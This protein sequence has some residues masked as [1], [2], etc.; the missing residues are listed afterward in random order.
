MGISPHVCV[1]QRPPEFGKGTSTNIRDAYTFIC[2]N[3]LG[4]GDEIILIGF[5]RRAFTV[6]CI[7]AF[8]HDVGLLT[9]TGLNTSTACIG[10]GRRRSAIVDFS[11]PQNT[12]FSVLQH[13]HQG[14]DIALLR[15]EDLLRTAIRIKVC[16]LWDTVSSWGSQCQ[17]HF[18]ND[19]PRS[20]L[21]SIQ[22][23]VKASRLRFSL[24]LNERRKHFQPIVM[25][26]PP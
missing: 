8:I 3:Y 19:L 6:R 13:E 23:I 21:L 20:L 16:A 5:S 22:N 7:A 18:L 17:A 26:T 12:D 2:H 10:S 4:D 9:R 14:T 1:V 24:A 11:V 15:A 25:K